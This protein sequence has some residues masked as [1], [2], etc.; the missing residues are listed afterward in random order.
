VTSQTVK[1]QSQFEPEFSE[2]ELRALEIDREEEDVAIAQQ[3]ED[4]D[5]GQHELVV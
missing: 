1:S 5:E 4:E 3:P 2:E